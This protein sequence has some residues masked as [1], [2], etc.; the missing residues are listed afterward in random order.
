MRVPGVAHGA[1]RIRTIKGAR[2]NSWSEIEVEVRDGF[3]VVPGDVS[4]MTAVHR[5]G[6]SNLG[7]QTVDHRGLGPLAAARLR[8]RI[9]TTSH[10]LVVYGHDPEE[11]ALAAN[12]VIDMGG[13]NAVVKD[14]RV[15]AQIAYPVA[16]MLSLKARPRSRASIAR[17]SRRRARSATGSRPTARS[18]RSRPVPRLQPGPHLTDLGLTDG[19]TKEIRP[20]LVASQ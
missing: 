10:N 2:F 4:V 5:H 14:G 1:R 9:R 19:G 7:P 20:I 12:T 6:R 3:A 18:R 8:P 11:M 13:G 16:G 15:I 17:W